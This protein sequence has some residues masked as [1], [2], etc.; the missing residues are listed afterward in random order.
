MARLARSKV[1]DPDQV[2]IGHFDNRT[3]RRLLLMEMTRSR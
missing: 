1:F 3:T 2:A